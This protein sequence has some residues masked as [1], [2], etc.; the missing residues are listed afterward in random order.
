MWPRVFSTPPAL[1]LETKDAKGTSAP[2]AARIAGLDPT[3]DVTGRSRHGPSSFSSTR[4]KAATPTQP[5]QALSRSDSQD[6]G[7][8]PSVPALVEAYRCPWR[9]ASFATDTRTG[10]QPKT[11]QHNYLPD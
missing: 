4:R 10:R 11:A 8:R 1:L 3:C 6:L 5:L 9:N 2:I 7:L